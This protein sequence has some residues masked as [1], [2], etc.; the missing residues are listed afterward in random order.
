MSIHRGAQWDRRLVGRVHAR[1]CVRGNRDS[2]AILGSDACKE[3][4]MARSHPSGGAVIAA[5]SLGPILGTHGE[6]KNRAS[7]GSVHAAP[8]LDTSPVTAICAC[9]RPAFRHLHSDAI[10]H[11]VQVIAAAHVRAASGDIK[12]AVERADSFCCSAGVTSSAVAE[13]LH[14][15]MRPSAMEDLEPDGW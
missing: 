8:P 6:S 15:F 1:Q 7:A 12:S 13:Q 2:L 3:M 11:G 14:G 10:V 4:I 5:N 9:L